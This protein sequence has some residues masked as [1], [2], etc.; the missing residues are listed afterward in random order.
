M[1]QK[2]D[3]DSREDDN[4]EHTKQS[5]QRSKLAQARSAF[6]LP[7]PIKRLFDATP[8]VTYAPNAKP[9]R[10]VESRH[11]HILHVFPEPTDAAEGHLSV[12]PS[13]LKWQVGR[14]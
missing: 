14:S 8:L 5:T 1:P 7:T 12:N 11:E 9:R 13:C 2:N 3:G 4:F 10:R 6:A